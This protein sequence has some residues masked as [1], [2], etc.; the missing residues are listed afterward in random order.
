MSERARCVYKL[1][2]K[3]PQHPPLDGVVEEAAFALVES[4]PEPGSLGPICDITRHHTISH[5]IT[6][7]LMVGAALVAF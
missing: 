7:C 2:G 4:H 1:Q 3:T 5:D 6:S